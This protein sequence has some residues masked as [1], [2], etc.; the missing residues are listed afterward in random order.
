MSVYDELF[1]DQQVVRQ[2]RQKLPRLFLLAELESQRNGKVGMEVG[3]VREKILIA[4]LMYKFGLDR[5]NTSIAI[6]EPEIDV[7]VDDEPLSIKTITIPHN[8]PIRGVKVSWS[9][10]TEAALKFKKKYFP[11]CDMMLAEIRWDSAGHLYL[12]KKHSQREILAKLGV[13]NYLKLPAQGRNTRGVELT[14]EALRLLAKDTSTRK[15]DIDFP[16]E[17][18]DYKEAYKRWLDA[19][20]ET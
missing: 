1:D 17:Q 5:V 11:S 3:S 13:G 14:G 15:I 2:I 4:L 19:W 10:D 7:I 16:H 12:F 8:L 20:R 18:L 6:T 9:V